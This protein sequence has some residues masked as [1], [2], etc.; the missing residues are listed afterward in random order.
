[1]SRARRLLLPAA[2]LVAIVT[3]EGGCGS[4]SEPAADTPTPMATK[5]RAEQA[6]K[7]APAPLAELHAQG[8]TLIDGG[9]EAFEARVAKLRGHPVVVNKWASW[10]PP[11]RAEFPFFQKQ[12]IKRGR[13]VAFVGVDSQ[14]NDADAAEFLAEYPVPFPSYKDPDLKIAAAMKAVGAFP[15]TVFYDER[16]EIV[17]L[18]QGGYATERELAADIE[19]YAR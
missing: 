11:C 3:V 4:S 13:E 16:G 6:L 14:D 5:R 18:K 19:R 9:A 2:L 1:M 10:C 12:A 15:S 17:H 7:G 8:G